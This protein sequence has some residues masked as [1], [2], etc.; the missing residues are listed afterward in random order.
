ML[1][2][3]RLRG[4]IRL[5][6]CCL[7]TA[8]AKQERPRTMQSW[9]RGREATSL[10]ACAPSARAESAEERIGGRARSKE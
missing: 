6:W 4:P 7:Q 2:R 1:R 8:F 10:A 5:Q 3:A 9:G